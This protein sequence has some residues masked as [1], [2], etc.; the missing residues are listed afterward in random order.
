MAK[1]SYSEL[2]KDPRWQRRRL[3]I[4]NRASFACEA[5]GC[6]T[7]TLHVHHRVYRKGA[8]PWEYA[9]REL[10]ALCEE[11]HEKE[12]QVRTRLAAALAELDVD[13]LEEVLGYAK[14]RRAVS[15]VFNDL[16]EENQPPNRAWALETYS[17]ARGFYVGIAARAPLDD[18]ERFRAM[19]PIDHGVVFVVAVHGL[20]QDKK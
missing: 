1:P 12:H 14:S 10:I 11:C 7:R 9:D 8:L 13:G 20:P 15:E 3:E 4:L 17:E 6:D 18:V 5:C 16:A 2:L 19:E